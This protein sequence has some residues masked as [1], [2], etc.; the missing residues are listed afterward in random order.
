MSASVKRREREY[1]ESH[2]DHLLI[3]SSGT[4]DTV[5]V[6]TNTNT[7]RYTHTHTK[8]K[9]K[10]LPVRSQKAFPSPSHIR[11]WAHRLDLKL[12]GAIQYG[13]GSEPSLGHFSKVLRK[14]P[15]ELRV[16]HYFRKWSLW[17]ACMNRAFFFF[18]RLPWFLILLFLVYL[19]WRIAHFQFQCSL[20]PPSVLD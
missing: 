18:F 14:L 15:E 1:A 4:T 12:L 19:C 20:R 13:P 17:Y 11:C 3:S 10:N 9:Y 7:H 16:S 5:I 8:L 6:H 2:S